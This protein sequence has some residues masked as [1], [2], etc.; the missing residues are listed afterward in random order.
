MIRQIQVLSYPV[1]L[2]MVLASGSVSGDNS[3]ERMSRER[4]YSDAAA[5]AARDGERFYHD[6]QADQLRH[7]VYEQTPDNAQKTRS[8]YQV[9]QDKQAQHRY[10]YREQS[11][12]QHRH[13]SGSPGRGAGGA[14]GGGGRGR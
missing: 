13:Q 7:R 6:E 2:T 5:E 4:L 10:Q 9:Q 8:Q 3:T 11:G 1:L 12:G 14:M